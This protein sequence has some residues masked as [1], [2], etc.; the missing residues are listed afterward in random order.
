MK[1]DIILRERACVCVAKSKWSYRAEK[2][3]KKLILPFLPNLPYYLLF[4]SCSDSEPKD[5][6]IRIEET[7]YGI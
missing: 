1:D 5:K 3:K 4:C 2:G 6:A 7:Q